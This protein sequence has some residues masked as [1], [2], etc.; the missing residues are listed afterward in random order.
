MIEAGEPSRKVLR[1]AVARLALAFWMVVH[2][3][4]GQALL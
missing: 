1:T 4:L 2:Q 3:F